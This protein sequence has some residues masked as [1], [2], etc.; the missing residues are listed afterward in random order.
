MF[1]YFLL[2]HIDGKNRSAT[3]PLVGSYIMGVFSANHILRAIDQIEVVLS[4]E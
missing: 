3:A 2:L 1:D 4:Y